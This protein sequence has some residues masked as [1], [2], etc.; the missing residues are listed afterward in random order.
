MATGVSFAKAF[1]A[2]GQ[3]HNTTEQ[4]ELIASRYALTSQITCALFDSS[5]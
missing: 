3:L 4:N 5:I 2:A 1:L